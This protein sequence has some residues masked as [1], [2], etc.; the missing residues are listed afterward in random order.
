MVV[1]DINGVNDFIGK[2]ALGEIRRVDHVLLFIG[3][4]LAQ[5][6]VGSLLWLISPFTTGFLQNLKRKSCR[7]KC[8]DGPFLAG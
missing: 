3:Q 2:R 1:E 5:V 6:E 8:L 7:E 4:S